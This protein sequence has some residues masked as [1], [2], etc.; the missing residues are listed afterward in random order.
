M[1]PHARAGQVGRG[2]RFAAYPRCSADVEKGEYQDGD[3]R[4]I[5]A[6]KPTH[7]RERMEARAFGAIWIFSAGFRSSC[8]VSQRLIVP[9]PPR[10]GVAPP[11]DART[12]ILAEQSGDAVSI[13]ERALG[14]LPNP[15]LNDRA[16]PF[17]SGA[18]S[19]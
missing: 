13:E 8:R 12:A 17:R 2:H 14:A 7:Q 15:V 1:P 18:A 3:R 10:W 11:Q 5:E 6:C 4:V 9:R 19:R 16:L